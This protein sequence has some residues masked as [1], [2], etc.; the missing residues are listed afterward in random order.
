MLFAYET[1]SALQAAERLLSSMDLL[2]RLQVFLLRKKFP[3][4]GTGKGPFAGVNPLVCN[5][6]RLATEQLL[7]LRAGEDPLAGVNFLV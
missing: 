5:E 7:A 6:F 2:M 4:L 3:A 1:F